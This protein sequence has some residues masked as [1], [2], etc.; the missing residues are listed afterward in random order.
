MKKFQKDV[1][2]NKENR[3]I[4]AQTEKQDYLYNKRNYIKSAVVIMVVQKAF[5]TSQVV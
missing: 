2:L 1:V 4:Q 3:V 5:H